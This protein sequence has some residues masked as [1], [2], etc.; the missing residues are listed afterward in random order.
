MT[1]E[2]LLKMIEYFDGD[3]KRIN[4]AIK[5]Y[6][7]AKLI[8]SK[9]NMEEDEYR[10]LELAAILHDIGIKNAERKYN[11]S[12]G[13]YQE[14]E[15]PAVAEELLNEFNIKK[16]ILERIKFLIGNHHSYNKID[17]I[18]FQI[19]I[20]SDFLVNIDEDNMKI[21]NIKVIKN[22]YFRTNMGIKLIE[23]MYIE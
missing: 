11:S 17:K 20:E 12:A 1:E 15:G 9:E 10:A 19:L 22:K 4:H 14:I 6:Q 5:V 8:S 13:K 21:E 2:I 23:S 18:D 3:V 7:F 16:D